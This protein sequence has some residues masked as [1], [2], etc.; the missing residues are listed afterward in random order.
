MKM[1]KVT[2]SFSILAISALLIT[3]CKKKTPNE[4]PEA[5]TEVQSS[6]DAAYAT[7][8]ISDIDMASSFAAEN[9]FLKHFYT[10]VPGTVG[11]MG[12][13][14]GSFTAT[15]DISAN[16]IIFSWNKTQCLDGRLRSGSIFMYWGFNTYF[17]PVVNPN[18]KYARDYQF[19]GAITLSDYR[20]DG[21]LIENVNGS[22][23]F[24]KNT[25]TSDKWDPSITNLTWTLEGKF[26]FTHPTDTSK[27]MVWDGKLFKTLTNTSNKNVFTLQKVGTP[28][29]PIDW[30]L[31]VV[32]YYG[33]ATGVTSRTVP[34]AM[35]IG[36]NNPITR[37]FTC[38][39]DKVGG[40]SIDPITNSVTVRYEEHHP[41][42]SGIASFTT[43]FGTKDEKYRRQIYF[44]NEAKQNP[45]LLVTPCD[46][47]GEVLIKGISYPITFMK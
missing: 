24:L 36:Q 21:W 20:V 23:A 25:L 30:T 16:A 19:C 5:D 6:I 26:K 43:G 45:D 15:R 41:F 7:Y 38:S 27:N 3:S 39:S 17:N 33:A 42:V 14:T 8:L 11:S 12:P 47:T 10:E 9:T 2:L 1:K 28:Q 44:A 22:P 40:V 18:A 4:A 37:D 34:F 32:N 35:L 13:S 29:T 31:G 46:N